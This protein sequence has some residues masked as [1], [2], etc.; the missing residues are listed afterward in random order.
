[1]ISIQLTRGFQTYLFLTKYFVDFVVVGYTDGPSVKNS[2]SSSVCSANEK[3]TLE[4]AKMKCDN[5]NKCNWLHDHSCDGKNWRFCSDVK[6]DDYKGA[7]G[8]S[9][10]K[11][12]NTAKFN[13]AYFIIQI[14]S[15]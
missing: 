3:G 8:C 15:L 1:M 2:A 13:T 11:P 5:D 7:G 4:W 6:I 14:L 10:I 9:K 12:G